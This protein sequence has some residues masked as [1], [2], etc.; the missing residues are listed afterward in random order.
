MTPASRHFRLRPALLGLLALALAAFSLGWPALALGPQTA[1]LTASVSPAAS[2]PGEVAQIAI[3]AKIAPGWHLYSLTPTPPPGPSPT[4]ITVTGPGITELGATEDS[5]TTELD[6]NFGKE[7]AFHENSAIFTVPVRVAA[8][9]PPGRRTLDISVQYQT[10]N[11]H[12]CL[13]PQTEALN[14]ALNVQPGATRTE[15]LNPPAGTA[16][17]SPAMPAATQAHTTSLVAFLAAAFLA[18]LLA[19]LTPCVFPV[20]PVTFGY[21]TKQTDGDRRKLIGLASAYAGGIILSFAGLGFVMAITLGAAGANR[22]AANPWVNLFFGILFV[23]FAFS[24]FE[25]FQ[26]RLPAA[27]SRFAAPA[28]RSG[29]WVGVLLMG[30]AFVFAAF[31]C[32]APFIGTVLVAAASAESAGAW[33]RPLAGMLAFAL[34]LALPF[35]LLALFPS[36]ITKLPRSGAWLTRFKAI[37]GFIEL[38][39]ALLYFSKADLVWQAGILTRPAIF[40]LW[41]VIALGGML[42]LLGLL[43]VSAYP[44]EM[45]R[46][47]VWRGIGA[48]AFALAAF[49]CL[50]A[51]TGR[52]VSGALVAYL[53]TADYGAKSAGSAPG[54][55][56]DGL[57]WLADYQTALA[58]ARAENKPVFIDFTGYTCTNCRYNELNVF[59]LPSVRSELS[60]Y[61]LVRLYTDGGPHYLDNQQFEAKR[62]GTVALPLY[63]VIGPGGQTIA[64]TA[65]TLTHPG[66]FAGFLS[67]GLEIASAPAPSSP[68]VPPTQTAWA[69]YSPQALAAAQAAGRPVIIDFTA[70]W[71]TVCHEIERTV[72]PAPD[73]APN[74]SRF[75]TL[76]ADLTDYSSP[77]N[78]A[79]E[80]QYK[81]VALPVVL[82][83][84]AQGHEIPGTRVTGLITAQDFAARMAKASAPPAGLKVAS[85]R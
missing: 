14:V 45:G 79:L 57:T 16:P 35:F 60:Q 77:Q 58:Q 9:S 76:R 74:L 19:L 46:L 37:L 29:G 13:P 51:L 55:S 44:E 11:S 73:V 3:A 28:R 67:H 48:G 17:A 34:A 5:P 64:E 33:A 40:A 26:I 8:G 80:K 27:L 31:T 38:A 49:Y 63:A 69:S 15:Y 71:C 42:Y 72:F 24:F 78:A 32:T 21:F 62:F 59:P 85:A 68:A 23:V 36:L 66:Q 43:R 83:L 53:P 1:T 52:P 18:G 20:I 75:T 81:I 7:V 56:T 84:D 82:F 65:G 25:A 30:L 2:H 50:Y 12:E 6:P 41:A 47:T 39:Y 54:A 70:N 10:C 61:V 22:V 4:S